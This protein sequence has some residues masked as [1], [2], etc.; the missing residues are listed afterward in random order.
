MA[1][2]QRYIVGETFPD[3]DWDSL[4]LY[5]LVGLQLVESLHLY[6]IS[7]CSES[8]GLRV[9]HSVRESRSGVLLS[10]CQ[11]QMT[12]LRL[13]APSRTVSK[14]ISRASH[15]HRSW[16]FL[17]Q[18]SLYLP[19]A[20]AGAVVGVWH[21]KLNTSQCAVY[22]RGKARKGFVFLFYCEM[23]AVSFPIGSLFH[24]PEPTR[25]SGCSHHFT[26]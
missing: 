22:A 7:L 3:F 26:L 9:G 21:F 18:G 8:S 6:F 14:R 16:P 17:P 19:G 2:A 15:T 11:T 12:A 5:L 10:E 23:L 13:S 24:S 4:N 1:C 25:R 20:V